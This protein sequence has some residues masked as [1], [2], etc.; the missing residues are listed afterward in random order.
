MAI[1]NDG[2]ANEGLIANSVRTPDN[3]FPKID[4]HATLSLQANNLAVKTKLGGTS[5]SGAWLG[6]LRA[7]TF[8][9]TIHLQGRRRIGDPTPYPS[10]PRAGACCGNASPLVE[11][12]KPCRS[13]KAHG[14]FGH[15]VASGDPTEDSVVLWTRLKPSARVRAVR[16]E[17][18]EDA[19]FQRPVLSSTQETGPERDFTIKR[20]RDSPPGRTYYYRFVAGDA[21]SMIGRTRTLPTGALDTLTLAIA[22]CSNYPF[23][24]FNGYDAIARDEQVDFVL[25]LGDYLYEYGPDS[26]GGETGATLGRVHAPAKEIVTLE[27]YRQ[28]HGQY[29]SDAGS[30]LMHA[31]HPLIAIWDDHESANN[32]WMGGAEN[33]Q[34]GAE[35]PWGLRRSFCSRPI[36]NGC[37]FA[38]LPPREARADYRR[39]FRFG[40]LASLVTLKTRH[41]GRAE[42]IDYRA[43]LTAE[44]SAE[45]IERFRSEV[46][47]APGAS[48]DAA[49]GRSLPEGR[50]FRSRGHRAAL[51]PPRQS[52]SHGTGTRA[53]PKRRAL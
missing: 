33:H 38:T 19:A 23:G 46:L 34:P 26:Y 18:A 48:H 24:H 53:I 17:L 42:Q 5:G 21:I 49:P 4:A 12:P 20:R 9:G 16:W 3:H 8:T 25:H 47:G 11:R 43:H 14:V 39:H 51:A 1:A 32:P 37:P 52:N 2:R 7:V 44:S 31:A 29:K 45:D 40:S 41:M 10:G 50:P 15:G 22:S 35:G 27:D 36:T 6:T 13:P 28:R 30:L